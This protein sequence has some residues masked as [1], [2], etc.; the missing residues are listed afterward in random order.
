MV[1]PD[2]ITG[3]VIQELVGIESDKLLRHGLYFVFL[4]AL[5]VLRGEKLFGVIAVVFRPQP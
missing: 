1:N 3:L 2:A 4:C 5:R